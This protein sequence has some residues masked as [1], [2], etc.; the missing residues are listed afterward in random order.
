MTP[1]Q[2][3]RAH[4]ALLLTTV[5][6]RPGQPLVVPYRREVARPGPQEI[7]HPVARREHVRPFGHT[8]PRPRGPVARHRRRPS[9]PPSV[10][11]PRLHRLGREGVPC[12]WVADFLH[13]LA[14]LARRVRKEDRRATP[15]PNAAPGA[16]RTGHRACPLSRRRGND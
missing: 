10:C 11:D 9:A 6:L 16:T 15:A 3:G 4:A 5:I 13:V 2:P 7:A 12:L 8:E 1:P 14:R